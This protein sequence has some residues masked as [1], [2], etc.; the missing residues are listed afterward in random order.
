MVV[1]LDELTRAVGP[2]G[3]GLDWGL[4]VDGIDEPA[5]GLGVHVDPIQALT[6]RKP[7]QE[8][9]GDV[10]DPTVARLEDALSYGDDV[11][12]PIP[13]AGVV[14]APDE[15]DVVLVKET[16]HPDPRS[17]Q[18]LMQSKSLHVVVAVVELVVVDS[19]VPVKVGLEGRDDMALDVE[20]QF[21]PTHALRQS[22]PEQDVLEIEPAVVV[23][24]KV[25][26]PVGVNCRLDVV[27][28][29]GLAVLV[30]LSAG[31]CVDE[32]VLEVTVDDVGIPVPN[33]QLGPRQILKHKAPEHD[34]V[35]VE[36]VLDEAHPGPKQLVTQFTPSQVVDN[37]DDRLDNVGL[38]ELSEDEVLVIVLPVEIL[39][40]HPE[41]THTEAQSAPLQDVEYEEERLDEELP[42]IDAE[43]VVWD[44]VEE[45][46]EDVKRLV[47]EVEGHAEPTQTEKHKAPLQDVVYDVEELEVIVKEV[48][49]ELPVVVVGL[50]TVWDE[51]EETADDVDWLDVV[52]GHPE[53]TQTE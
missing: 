44:E 21:D 18:S 47:E 31:D 32:T 52:D 23:W 51:M 15:V 26:D 6:Q 30:V 22:K 39:E 17:R 2:V 16:V 34:G 29:L 53:P 8:V 9:V 43:L 36:A 27:G 24:S 20:G 25:E 38:P 40:G 4:F 10:N 41:P 42:V 48:T 46:T 13:L 28:V 19:G 7:E 5:V 50:V 45:M 3:L 35:G 14:T 49:E 12:V 1:P 33:V 37:E 11:V